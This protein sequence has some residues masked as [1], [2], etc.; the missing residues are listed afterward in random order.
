M[1]HILLVELN[2]AEIVTEYFYPASR[3]IVLKNP[4]NSNI[5]SSLHIKNK[6]L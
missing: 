2:V 6:Q 4:L 3:Y 5:D 1:Y